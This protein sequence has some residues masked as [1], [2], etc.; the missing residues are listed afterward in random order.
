MKYLKYSAIITNVYPDSIGEELGLEPGDKLVSVNGVSSRD[1]IELSFQLAEEELELLIEKADGRQ[2]FIDLEKDYD[3]E[4]GLEFDSAVFDGV[5]RCGNKCVFCFVDQMPPNMRESL[6]VK[7][8]DYRLSFLYGNFVTLTN[9]S[10][11]DLERI[12]REHLSPLYVSVHTT[13]ENLRE[14]MLGNRH[15]GKIYTQLKELIAHDIEV[16]TQIVLCPGI[17]D[18]PELEKTINDLFKLGPNVLSA[19]IVPVGLTRYRDNCYSLQGFTPSE[20]QNII[21]NVE[22]WQVKFREQTGNSF[23]YLADEF[24]LAA[25]CTIPEYDLYDGFPQLENGIGIVRSFIDEWQQADEGN[26]KTYQEPHY[27]SIVC[28]KSAEKVLTPLLEDLQVPNLNVRVVPVENKF[29][30]T[31]ITVTGLLTGQD[32][33]DTVAN[34]S[35][36]HTGIILPGVALR[37]GED[38]FLDNMSLDKVEETLNIPVRV[39]YGAAELKEY[40]MNW[41]K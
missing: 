26:D 27:L 31:Q 38:V 12:Y 29:F 15:A 10:P 16:H 25:G 14:K 9:S 20:A 8:D 34:I 28:G 2:E 6:Y 22:K 23:V 17:N 32:I 33:I 40:L 3:D 19:A 1:L 4:L 30:G 7:D 5:R 21:K 18:G 11:K 39:A 35:G 36:P 13:N 41:D 24:Y 37:K